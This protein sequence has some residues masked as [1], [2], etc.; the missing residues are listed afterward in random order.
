MTDQIRQQVSLFMDDELSREECAFFVRRLQRDQ[1]SRNLYMRYQIIGAAIRGEHINA[2]HATLRERLQDALG[3]PEAR[4]S[5][6][7]RIAGFV[8]GAGRTVAGAG[9]AAG[10]AAAA[11]LLLR[12]GAE[13]PGTAASAAVPLADTRLERV[14]PPS[15]VVPLRV[16]ATPVVRP[17]VRLTGLQYLMHHGGHASGLSRTVVHTNMLSADNPDVAAAAE[18]VE[19]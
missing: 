10:V 1:E 15:Y 12:P 7:S 9:I 8:T 18:V 2:N 11:L 17:E 5:A 4:A 6:R 16:P 13:A 14:E 3:E 19:P